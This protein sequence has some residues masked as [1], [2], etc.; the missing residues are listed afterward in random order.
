MVKIAICDDIHKELEEN[1]LFIQEYIKKN[2]LSAEIFTFSNPDELCTACETEQFQ[3]YLLDMVMPM[4][5]GVQLGRAIR[6]IDSEAQIIYIT[7][8][9]EFAIDSFTAQ[10]IGYLLKPI[11]KIKL[12]DILD[13]AISRI[14][15]N[16]EEVI[17]IKTKNGIQ[18]L[19]LVSIAL[20]E[21]VRHAVVFTLVNG[22]VIETTTIVGSFS[23][24]IIPIIKNNRFIHP[25]TS[26]VV[27]MSQVERLTREGFNLKSGKFI[28]I[29]GK[30]YTQ[31]RDT[32]LDYRLKRETHA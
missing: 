14:I 25:H 30:Q 4:M 10:P 17:T 27:N 21:Y 23:N 11:D 16:E 20:C 19:S 15:R 1:V 31:V 2:K 29:S 6:N 26:F 5:S 32:Y 24:F 22:D 13:I 9:P 12:F 18:T 7:T 3:L 8:A 28:P